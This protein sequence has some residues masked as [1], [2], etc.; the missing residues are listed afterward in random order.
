M[1]KHSPYRGSAY[2]VHK[3]IAEVVNKERGWLFYGRLTEFAKKTRIDRKTINAAITQMVRHGYLKELRPPARMV[4]VD[5]FP[6]LVPTGF[7]A[8]YKFVFVANAPVVYDAEGKDLARDDG[9]EEDSSPPVGVI[10]V[11]D[12][13][14]GVSAGHDVALDDDPALEF[15]GEEI[16]SPPTGPSSTGEESASPG[17]EISSRGEESAARNSIELK[18]NFNKISPNPHC[19][20]AQ[21]SRAAGSNPRALGTDPRTVG[22]NPRALALDAF[23]DDARRDDEHVPAVGTHLRRM[24]T[25]LSRGLGPG[26]AQP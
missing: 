2:H 14:A 18:K 1:V 13:H 17:E 21:G 22:T 11:D 20:G 24:H 4:D 23:F 5:G 10:P 3:A 19:V 16:A 25:A 8:V 15:E 9:G 26:G 7:P 12:S 6:K